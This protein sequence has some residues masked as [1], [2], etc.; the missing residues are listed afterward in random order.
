M[1]HY[2]AIAAQTDCPIILYNVPGRTA[3]D[4]SVETALTLSKTDTIVAIKE[5]SG[6]TLR[7]QEIIECCGDDLVVLSGEDGLTL[8]LM[9]LG[10]KGVISVT[11]NVAPHQM[12]EMCRHALEKDF[13]KAQEIDD[14]LQPL[15]QAL[16]LEANPIP[17]KWALSQ[18]G[19]SG[20][21][22]RQPLLPLVEGER[23]S[24]TAVLEQLNLL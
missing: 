22:L 17:C 21:S 10:A 5:A 1:E 23:A 4:L 12:H 24:V 9:R 13:D 6:S 2:Q 20:P 7:T 18:M 15:H 11:A 14:S 19:L 3:C 16:F 8:E